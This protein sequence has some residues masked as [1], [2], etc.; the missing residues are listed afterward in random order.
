MPVRILFLIAFVLLS[1][2]VSFGQ[3][4]EEEIEPLPIQVWHCLAGWSIG[5]TMHYEVLLLDRSYQGGTITAKKES[6]TR[7]RVSVVDSS[8]AGYLLRWQWLISDPEEMNGSGLADTNIIE[9]AKAMSTLDMTVRTGPDGRLIAVDDLEGSIIDFVGNFERFAIKYQNE[10]DSTM[11]S[12]VTRLMALFRQNKVALGS[13]LFSNIELFFSP[14]GYEV[15]SD[16]FYV[17]PFEIRNGITGEFVPGDIRVELKYVNEFSYQF[18]AIFDPDHEEM[19]KQVRETLNKRQKTNRA[20]RYSLKDVRAF[21]LEVQREERFVIHTNNGWPKHIHSVVRS[22]GSGTRREVERTVTSDVYVG[23]QKNELYYDERIT[24]QPADPRNYIERADL[25]AE[26]GDLDGAEEDLTMAYELDPGISVLKQRAWV[27]M[28]LLK[29]EEALEDIDAALGIDSADVYTIDQRTH[30]LFSLHR[31]SEAYTNAERSM[32]IQP[33]S[34]Y[35]MRQAGKI[36]VALYNYPE[37]I[38][39]YTEILS[40]DT[41]D[42]TTLGLRAD[43]YKYLRTSQGDSLAQV[44]IERSLAIQPDNYSALITLGNM[45]MDRGDLA[46]AIAVFDTILAHQMDMTALHNR[47]YAKVQMGALDDGIKDL[48]DAL[49]LEPGHAYGPNNLGWAYH[50]RGEHAKALQWID[51]GIARQPTNSYAFFN[52]GR[53]LLAMG[54][55]QEACEALYEADRLGFTKGYGNMVQELREKHCSP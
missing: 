43:A 5:D 15:L 4:E 24:A 29:Y 42:W 53:V 2:L 23:R 21:G 48:E 46:P 33:D 1:P 52:K 38:A 18:E 11:S 30:A 37:A 26:R 47:G 3:E 45:Y 36:L 13:A 16:S 54:Q 19:T 51:K 32:R 35:S 49:D 44:D 27:R 22:A 25:R 28:E 10:L 7:I 20:K 8:D 6:S 12:E 9:L 17:A 55:L 40:R 34:P 14:F 31:Y 39:I 41:S 50:L